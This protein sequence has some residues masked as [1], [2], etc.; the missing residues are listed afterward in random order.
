MGIQAGEADQLAAV[1][2]LL[3]AEYAFV[4]RYKQILDDVKSRWPER[5]AGNALPR[6]HQMLM[7]KQGRAVAA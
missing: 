2:K 6:G 5:S 3:E 4:E 7:G 1:T